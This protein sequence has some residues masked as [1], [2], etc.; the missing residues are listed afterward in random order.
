MSGLRLIAERRLVV[1]QSKLGDDAGDYGALGRGRV[2]QKGAGS[3]TQRV[4][5]VLVRRYRVGTLGKLDDGAVRGAW[6]QVRYPP[7]LGAVVLVHH[8]VAVRGEALRVSDEFLLD[9]VF[10]VVS[11]SD[12]VLI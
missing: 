9:E 5:D 1:E 10:F 11:V 7:A 4:W 8:R 6:R 3:G 12:L 2:R